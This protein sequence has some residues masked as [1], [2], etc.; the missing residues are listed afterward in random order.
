VNREGTSQ[1]KFGLFQAPEYEKNNEGA[2]SNKPSKEPRTQD[3]AAM[4]TQ[5]FWLIRTGYLNG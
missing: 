3:A 2:T 4:K 1:K 5:I